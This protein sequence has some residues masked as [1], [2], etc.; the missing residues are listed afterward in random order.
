M[1]RLAV[2]GAV[3]LSLAL[4]GDR[5]LCEFVDAGAPLGSGIGGKAVLLG[6]GGS[7]VFVEQVRL[8]ALE[9]RPE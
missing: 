4:G 1:F 6:G 8:T 2:R 9:R 3:S 7:R 5:S